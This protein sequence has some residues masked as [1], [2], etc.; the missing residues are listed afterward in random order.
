MHR[1]RHA[2]GE[3]LVAQ[4]AAPSE[5]LRVRSGVVVLSAVD[6]EGEERVCCLR[7]PGAVLNAGALTGRSAAFRAEA[8]T[9]VEVCLLPRERLEDAVR[10]EGPAGLRLAHLLL[11]EGRSWA[12]GSLGG[13]GRKATSRVAALLLE[14]DDL[15]VDSRGVQRRLLAR[16]LAIRPETLS[17]SLRSL[18]E[19]GAIDS[20]GAVV[21]SSRL[22][23][24]ARD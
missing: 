9:P 22:R 4:G 17:R 13:S 21:D 3:L 11:S 19:A 18:R 6:A 8:L 24:L 23:R 1:R 5:L 15:G 10:Q 14:L 12:L 2:A 16:V 20:V 7:G